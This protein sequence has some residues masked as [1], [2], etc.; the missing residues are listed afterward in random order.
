MNNL[1]LAQNA[2]LETN[3]P[4][5]FEYKFTGKNHETLPWIFAAEKF[6]RINDFNTPKIRFQRIFTSL[7]NSYQNRYFLDTEDN[8]E[9]TTFESLKTWVLKRYPPPK[10]KHEFKIALK[11]MT[12]YKGEDPNI[13]YSRWNYKLAK[14]KSAIKIIN[15]GLNAETAELYPEDDFAVNG[16]ADKHYKSI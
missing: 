1:L 6:L 4:A 8:D 15:E 13:A 9:N 10:T 3:N 11:S 14:I 16:P 12:M 2:L 7:N 5:K